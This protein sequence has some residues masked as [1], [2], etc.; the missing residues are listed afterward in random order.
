MSK[1]YIARLTS[2]GNKAGTFS[3]S[4]RDKTSTLN[5]EPVFAAQLERMYEQAI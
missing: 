4:E 1:E 2:R 3:Y 5:P